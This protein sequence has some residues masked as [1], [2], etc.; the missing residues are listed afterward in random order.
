MAAFAPHL[1]D[2]IILLLVLI[3]MWLGFR[4]GI[5]AG[6]FFVASGFG[7]MAAAHTYASRAHMNEALFFLIAVAVICL[8]GFGL[9]KAMKKMLLKTPDRIGGALLGL[10]LGV[11]LVAAVVMPSAER[12]VPSFRKAAE[13]SYTG[14]RV[15]PWIR[16]EI[17]WSGRFPAKN[18]SLPRLSFPRSCPFSFS[19]KKKDS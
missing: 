17:P 3:I 16:K 7:S 6:L 4:T 2:G 5:I 9:S 11:L 18:V 19:L 8:V 1:V 12:C 10:C 14:A 13:T 15:M